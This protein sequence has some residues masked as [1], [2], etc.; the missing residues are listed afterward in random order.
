M[1]VF[2]ELFPLSADWNIIG[3]LLGLPEDLLERIRANEERAENRLQK[4]LSGWLKQVDP[5]PTWAALAEAVEPVDQVKAQDIKTRYIDIKI[6][7]Q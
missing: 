3:M 5:R 2:R 6:D 4:V 7:L 1:D